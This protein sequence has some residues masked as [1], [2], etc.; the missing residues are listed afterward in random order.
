[1]GKEKCVD[2]MYSAYSLFNS[3]TIDTSY[4]PDIYV[5]NPRVIGPRAAGVYIR[6]TT[7][8]HGITNM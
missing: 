4:L 6:Q 8:A 2:T 3:Y 5:Q 1:M 7:N